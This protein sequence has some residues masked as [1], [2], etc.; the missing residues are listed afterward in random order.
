MLRSS[1]PL[2]SAYKSSCHAIVLRWVGVAAA[3]AWSPV[4]LHDPM[5]TR[6]RVRANVRI[7]RGGLLRE[8][9]RLV[10]GRKELLARLSAD[11]E[12]E[13]RDDGRT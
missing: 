4:L 1:R 8:Q 10:R 11:R 9:S 13:R 6:Q 3:T 5:Q 2:F 7:S 12:R